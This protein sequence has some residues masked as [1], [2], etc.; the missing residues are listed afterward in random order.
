VFFINVPVA[1]ICLWLVLVNAKESRGKNSGPVDWMGAGAVTVGLSAITWA[2]TVAPGRGGDPVVLSVSAFGAVAL[3]SFAFI[4]RRALNP[5][6]PLKLFRSVTFSGVNAV[7][8]VLYA[9]FGAA[10]FLL[11][12]ELIRVQGYAPSAA[13]AGLLP[14][15]VAL[16]VLSPLAGRLASRIGAR[17]M[18][19]VGPLLAAVGFG[20]LAALADGASY[21]TSVF[22]GLAVLAV[23][24]GIAVAPLTDAVLGAVADEYEGAAAGVNNAVARVAGLLAVALLGFVIGGS[25]TTAIAAGYRAAMIVAALASGAAGMVAGFTV[26]PKVRTRAV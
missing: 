7:T 9:A 23:G 18:L 22:P 20:L 3:A 14:M 13:G 19:I 24:A 10:F 15:S 25:D 2:L 12:F 21:W 5:M 11:P 1:A 26:K 16:V 4:E 8:L 17:P 6:I